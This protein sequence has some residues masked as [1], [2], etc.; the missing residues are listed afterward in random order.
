MSLNKVAIS[1]NLGKDSE[2]RVTQGGTAVLTFSVAV[3]ERRRQQDGAY[4]DKANWIDCVM[5]GK[6]AEGIQPY[7]RR[8]SKLALTGHL[9][10]NKYEHDGKTYSRIE[11]V[12]DEVELMNTRRETQQPEAAPAQPSEPAISDAGIPF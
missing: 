11:V 1:G 9:N 7:L 5:F 8:G 3:N 2:L 6:R 4:Q 10:Q 12:V